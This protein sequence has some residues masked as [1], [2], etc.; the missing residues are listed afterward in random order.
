MEFIYYLP[1]LLKAVERM[2]AEYNYGKQ[3]VTVEE[4]TAYC[5]EEGL[6]SPLQVAEFTARSA[7][8]AAASAAESCCCSVTVEQPA[9]FVLEKALTPPETEAAWATCPGSARCGFR[10]E[11]ARAENKMDQG[12]LKMASVTSLAAVFEEEEA[13]QVDIGELLLNS[14]EEVVT[15]TCQYDAHNFRADVD[16]FPPASFCCM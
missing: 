1:S 16:I 15:E 8:T 12:Q 14:R 7:A 11:E 2:N 3:S 10:E 5:I 4:S 6:Q 13:C 9:T